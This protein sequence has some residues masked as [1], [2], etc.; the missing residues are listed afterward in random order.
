MERKKQKIKIVIND[1]SVNII[2]RESVYYAKGIKNTR[3]L[4]GKIYYY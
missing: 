2:S 3:R 4:K 1:N